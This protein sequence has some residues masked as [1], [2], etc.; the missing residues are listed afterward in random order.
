[1]PSEKLKKAGVSDERFDRC[2]T[3]VRA[4][5]KSSGKKV[6]PFAVCEAS[7]Q[8]KAGIR[9]STPKTRNVRSA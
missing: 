1:M 3:R 5:A 7:L 4:E 9:G 6:N 8:K 2:V